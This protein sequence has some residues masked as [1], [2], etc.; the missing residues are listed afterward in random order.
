[1]ENEPVDWI[2]E[3]MSVEEIYEMIERSSRVR[4]EKT[5][6]GGIRIILTAPNRAAEE[7]LESW[8]KALRGHEESARK[9]SEFVNSIMGEI[10]KHLRGSDDEFF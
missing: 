8:K 3:V 6:K 4:M 10:E 1:V 9:V 2:H 7:M 5:D